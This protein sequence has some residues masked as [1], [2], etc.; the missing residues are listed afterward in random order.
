MAWRR[1]TGCLHARLY[2]NTRAMA[3]RKGHKEVLQEHT[4][5]DGH[6]SASLAWQLAQGLSA[7]THTHVCPS[8]LSYLPVHADS[9]VRHVRSSYTAS[10]G[11]LSAVRRLRA[12]RHLRG[13]SAAVASPPGG[14]TA[15]APAGCTGRR[16]CETP[17]SAPA[18]AAGR[19]VLSVPCTPLP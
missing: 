3:A 10:S 18:A 9:Q 8:T 1:I 14:L 13:P 2:Q 12:Y 4:G 7:G 6:E 11:M 19:T 17:A 15:L 5:A 16:A